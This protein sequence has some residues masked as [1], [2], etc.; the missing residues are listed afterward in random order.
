MIRGSCVCGTVRFETEGRVS[1]ISMCHCSVCRK[2]FGGHSNAV[3]VT[4]AKRFRFLSGEDQI[5]GYRRPSGYRTSFCGNCGCPVPLEHESGKLMML[6]AG[7]LDDDPG[8]GVARHIFVGS[9]ASW[10]EI[11]D[12]APQFDTWPPEDGGRD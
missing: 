3:L 6:P 7:S 5:R 4:A 12:A 1:P 10:D 2:S 8:V 11:G 9:K